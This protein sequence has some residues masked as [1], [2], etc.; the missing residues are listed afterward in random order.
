VGE[1]SELY[2]R[3][4]EAWNERDVERFLETVHPEFVLRSRLTDVEGTAYQGHAGVRQ[5][6]TDLAE[7]FNELRMEIEEIEER[8]DWVVVTLR[9]TGTGAASGAGLDVDVIS[10]VRFRDGLVVQSFTER[11]KEDV[12]AAA[13]LE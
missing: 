12:L 8:G 2:R 6:F 10:A 3:G 5:Y 9:L 4:L 1:K 7:A 13:G 11:T